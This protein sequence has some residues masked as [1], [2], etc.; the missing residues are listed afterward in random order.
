ME[1][2]QPPLVIDY[3]RFSSDL[4]RHGN[5][6]RRQGEGADAY[7]AS[8]GWTFDRRVSDHGVSAYRGRNAKTGGLAAILAGIADGSIPEGSV[9]V[10]EE[11]DRL[12]RQS[13]ELSAGLFLQIISSGVTIVTCLSGDVREYRPGQLDLGTV[14]LAIVKLAL[15]AEESEKKGRRSRDNWARRREAAR[16]GTAI[17][18]R[19]VPD[20]C[21]VEGGRIVAD[22]AK[23]ATLR[24]I[25]LWSRDGLGM[26]DICGRLR[27]GGHPTWGRAKRWTKPRVHSVLTRPEPKG[28][29]RQCVEGDGGGRQCVAELPD[30]YPAV[31]D[32]DLWDEVQSGL[33]RRRVRRK[34][35]PR[36]R[37]VNLLNG[38]L[39]DH[40]G[41][42]W[43]LGRSSKKDDRH[44]LRLASTYDPAIRTVRIP[45]VV[46]ENLFLAAL[47]PAC[48]AQLL[49]STS[50]PGRD[51]A[52]GDRLQARVLS[53]AHKAATLRAAIDADETGDLA[54]LVAS[55][56]KA[57]AERREAEAALRAVRGAAASTD[58][59][60]VEALV[61]RLDALAA[62][63]LPRD[64]R[65]ELAG[66]LA[67]LVDRANLDAVRRG[68]R[69]D[70]VL[71][72]R[73]RLGEPVT[74]RFEYDFVVVRTDPPDR[75]NPLSR[76][77][78]EPIDLDEHPFSAS[79]GDPSTPEADRD[80]AIVAALLMP[81]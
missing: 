43:T 18:T 61:R 70:G 16:N 32:A 69:I 38:L 72:I 45:A 27:D 31:V 79:G 65:V 33:E 15:A 74:V 77:R 73:P 8:K 17:M 40:T 21:R 3:S 9:L 60:R 68:G 66:V 46:V 47:V 64:D 5:S 19:S 59:D 14:M 56:A 29:Y 52:E 48:H 81:H 42:A 23:A 49:A 25:Y 4:Q 35:G 71:T 58:R 20:W 13:I 36:S 78:V 11:L 57:E 54:P 67:N 53:L 34:G 2:E 50:V 63:D 39:A 55:V 22:P 80:R 7:V 10:V 37:Y 24:Q 75:R 30:Y 6:A 26:G 44:Y 12:S 62:G 76:L 28:I 1:P 51:R 41:V